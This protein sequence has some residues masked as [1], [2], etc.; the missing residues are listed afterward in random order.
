MLPQ[1][2]DQR[3]N[4]K[5]SLHYTKILDHAFG[6]KCLNYEVYMPVVKPIVDSCLSGF[7]GTI[8]TYGSTSSG[9]I[10]WGHRVHGVHCRT[11]LTRTNC[12]AGKNYTMLGNDADPG[13]ILITLERLFKA[14]GF[15]QRTIR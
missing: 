4:P 12:F 13:I 6:T 8:L 5:Q 11:L 9:E 14:S 2:L 7:N 1:V 10:H 15:F 3:P